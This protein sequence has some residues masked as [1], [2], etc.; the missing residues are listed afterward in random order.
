MNA[1]VQI[2]FVVAGSEEVVVET[3]Q[4]WRD[5][6]VD[7]GIEII[8]VEAIDENGDSIVAVA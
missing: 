6:L 2:Q 8:A 5:A 4:R 3:V 1:S 7:A